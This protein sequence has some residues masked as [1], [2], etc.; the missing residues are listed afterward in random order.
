[1]LLNVMVLCM[2]NRKKISKLTASGQLPDDANR[3]DKRD[4]KKKVLGE[5]GKG[6]QEINTGKKPSVQLVSTAP[7]HNNEN[8]LDEPP[9]CVDLDGTL[10]YSDLLIESCLK[11]LKQ[12]PLYFL[13]LPLWLWE[14]KAVLKAEIAKRVELDVSLL[15]Y[16]KEVLDYIKE[17]KAAGRKIVLATASN[18]KYANAVAKH[19][20]LFDEVFASNQSVNLSGGKKAD[21]LVGQYGKDGFD[22]M[23]DAQV[24]VAV[25]KV[26]RK[27]LLVEIG[28]NTANMLRLQNLGV[29][30]DGVPDTTKNIETV[31]ERR[32]QFKPLLK[33][34][35]P[36]HWLKN[37][38]IFVPVFLVHELMNPVF[39][40]KAI[41][42]FIA[43]SLIASS[44]YLLNDLFD[45]EADRLHETKRN[46]PLASGLLQPANALIALPA[47]IMVA[48]GLSFIL[49]W[50]FTVALGIY[51]ISNIIYTAKLKNVMLADTILLAGMFTL[52]IIAGSFAISQPLSVWLISFSMFTFFSLALV[53]RVVELQKSKLKNGKSIPGRGYITADRDI[54]MMFG[55]SSALTAVAI[56][57]LYINGETVRVLYAYPNLIWLICPLVMYLLGRVWILASRKQMNED[58]V[59]FAIQDRQS[60]MILLSAMTIIWLASK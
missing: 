11:L 55:I 20:G 1:M 40:I 57:A 36:K 25:W 49:P 39:L 5:S 43:F 32:G 29:Q 4:T 30:A 15:P 24:D 6:G 44:I 34:I 37:A 7:R 12:N 14:G 58:P 28:Q 31:V 52:R 33:S 60:Q 9:L 46:R 21:K 22:Y 27:S 45:L 2:S 8:Y 59:M 13:W 17:Q 54:L 3:S 23:G 53:K 50:V 47:F 41:L 48:F 19:L 35:R 51:L 18:I 38:L 16:R 56:L 42:A 26:S 10:I